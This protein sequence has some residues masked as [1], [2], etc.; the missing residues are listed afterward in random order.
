MKCPQ[1]I[2]WQAEGLRLLRL[3]LARWAL[4]SLFVALTACAIVAGLQAQAWRQA[5]SQDEAAYA[6]VW[7][8]QQQRLM[9]ATSSG[10]A[11]AAAVYQVGR[12]DLGQTRMPV[13]AGLSLG[14][15][16]LHVLPSRI[17][18]SLETRQVDSRDPGPLHNPLLID[19]GVPGLPAMVALLGS[20]VALVLCAGLVQEER[21]QGRL[22]FLRVQSRH[23][24]APVLWAALGWRWL[25][26]W[27]VAAL[28]T[29]PAF[30]L[31]PGASLL[32]ALWWQ[33]AL[34]AFFAVWVGAGGLLS[35]V[36]LNGAACMLAALGLWLVSTFAVPAALV[37]GAQKA[38]P[39]PSRLAAVVALRNAQHEAEDNEQALAEAWYD[40]HPDIAQHLP[41]VWPASF[42]VRTLD[43]DAAL[44]PLLEQFSASRAG[45]ARWVSA[46]SW[47]SPG[48]ALV[49]RG[50]QLAGTDWGSHMRYVAQVDAFEREWRAFLVPL[51]M[52]QQGVSGQALRRLPRFKPEVGPD[53]VP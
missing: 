28:A 22:G 5:A 33:V 1:R 38:A 36:P 18:V 49:L 10:Q 30:V 37:V 43:Q 47:L 40:E 31:D 46:W 27:L 32:A 39:M 25:A 2:H 4:G 19:L 17:K 52:G 13:L 11:S 48:L 50:E 12:S 34:A 41:A 14:V 51:V 23:G 45:Q 9:Q 44:Q 15:Q 29:A 20:L 16:R 21:E 24:L 6:A 8:A 53:S 35:F 3:P 42:V 7:Q 26:L